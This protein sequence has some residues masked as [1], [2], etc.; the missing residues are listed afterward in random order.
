MT[1][2]MLLYNKTACL[3][4]C[5]LRVFRN[6]D[7]WFVFR[8][9]VGWHSE[10]HSLGAIYLSRLA[11]STRS[12]NVKRDILGDAITIGG[13]LCQPWSDSSNQTLFRFFSSRQ[14]CW[15]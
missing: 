5:R 10:C 14:E 7:C 8:S 11:M 2:V 1:S 12:Q 4:L 9:P 3:N 15:D 13:S 6:F